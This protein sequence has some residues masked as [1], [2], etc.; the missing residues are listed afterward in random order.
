MG[1]RGREKEI[2]IAHI[3]PCDILLREKEG[4]GEGE[5]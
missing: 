2:A 5:G 4:E 1:V 3:K